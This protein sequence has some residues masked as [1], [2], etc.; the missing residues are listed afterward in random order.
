MTNTQ[1]KPESGGK[2]V[3]LIGYLTAIVIA[4]TAF[5]AAIDAFLNQADALLCKRFPE[6]PV[7]CSEKEL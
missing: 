6:F 1:N 3:K 4:G 7:L 2:A 5:L